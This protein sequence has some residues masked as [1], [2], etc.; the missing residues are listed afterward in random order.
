[1]TKEEKIA[2]RAAENNTGSSAS[3]RWGNQGSRSSSP[4]WTSI[5]AMSS[6]KEDDN[7]GQDRRMTAQESSS[8]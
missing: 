8:I 1:M 5:G 6:Q 4:D 7:G 3:D 2:T